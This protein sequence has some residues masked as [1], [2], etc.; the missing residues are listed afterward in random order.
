MIKIDKLSIRFGR[1]RAVDDLSLAIGAGE[2]ILLAGANGAGKTTLLRAMA[3]VLGAD[4]GSIRYSGRRADHRARRKIAYIPASI[5]LYDSMTVKEAARLHGHFFGRSPEWVIDGPAFPPGQRI[6][7]MSKGEKTIFFL[8]LA[9]AAAPEYLFVDD[10][11][12][13]LDPHLREIFLTSILRPI[14]EK[15]LTVIL[16]SQSAFEIEGIPERVLVMEKG[17]IIL[18]ESVDMLKQRFVKFYAPEIP[19]GI[20]VVF[21]RQWQNA[22]EIFVYPYLA[23]THRL[24]GVEH[25]S[26]TEILRAYIGGEYARH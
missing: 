23:E 22:R 20:P 24:Q 11:I 4:R 18:D 7:S 13:F 21:S 19:P 2:S 5:S 16:A 1:V 15:Q 10:V 9:L 14:E 25:L 3:G 12:H 26:L 17:R 6:A 8:S